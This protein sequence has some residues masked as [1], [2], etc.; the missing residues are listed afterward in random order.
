[1]G[2]LFGIGS[3]IA[4]FFTGI[5]I[6]GR[7]SWMYVFFEILAPLIKK[8]IA[9]IGFTTITLIGINTVTDAIVTYLLTRVG[10]L[11]SDVFSMMGIMQ[12]D[13]AISLIVSVGAIKQIMKGWD[14]L[15]DKKTNTVWNKP[16]RGYN[17]PFSGN[18]TF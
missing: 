18:K 13:V 16:N 8:I 9:L 12:L 5:N 14:L 17:E 7:L 4:R 3:H 1:M 11:P 10:S 2:Y 15:A 6:A